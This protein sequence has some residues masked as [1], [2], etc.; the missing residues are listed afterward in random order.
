MGRRQRETATS[1]HA[2][3]S[4]REQNVNMSSHAERE[5]TRAVRRAGN[6]AASATVLFIGLF[7]LSSEIESVRTVSPWADD[8]WDAVMSIAALVVPVVAAMT[9]I[10]A[11]RWRGGG[12]IP[13]A[14]HGLVL[15]GVLVVLTGIAAAILAGIGATAAAG[16]VP[17]ILALP[18]VLTGTVT[19]VASGALF[20]AGHRLRSMRTLST[21]AR[22]RSPDLFDDM[23]ALARDVLQG[24]RAPSGGLAA[25]D[26]LDGF[27]VR[28]RWSPRAH[29]STFALGL[30]IAFGSGFSTWH[31]LAEG[32]FA[33][34]GS[35]IV[36]VIYATIGATIALCAYFGLGGYLRIVVR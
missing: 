7:W 5:V 9:F 14:A 24:P 32:G 3:I 30:A 18:L 21:N 25:V 11:Q 36:W 26:R 2:P 35:L 28:S 20:V 22:V 8:P 15:R 17:W 13:L 4:P 16:G 29:P 12:P 1:T 6:L 19:L 34:G 23:I 31:T 33:G 10:R 27:L